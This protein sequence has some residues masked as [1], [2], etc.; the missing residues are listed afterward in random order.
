MQ[1]DAVALLVRGVMNVMRHLGMIDAH[2]RPGNHKSRMT[3]QIRNQRK[4]PAGPWLQ[5]E[6]LRP[7]GRLNTFDEV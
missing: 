7:S 4:R 2:A 6:H 1:E 5:Q 3:K